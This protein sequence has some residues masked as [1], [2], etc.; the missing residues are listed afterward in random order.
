MSIR[1]DY[2]KFSHLLLPHTVFNYGRV[3]IDRVKKDKNA[4]VLDL[5]RSWQSIQ[6]ESNDSRNDAPSF[7]IDIRKLDVIHNLIILTI[8]ETIEVW[9]T[10]YIGIT[11]DDAYNIRYFTYEIGKTIE[12]KLVFFLCQLTKSGEHINYGKFE[13]LNVELFVSEISDIMVYD[14]L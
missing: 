12:D 2:Y 14:L 3:A 7:Q 5:K 4:F 8:P 11:F 9:E 1:E 10:P 6:I 13:E